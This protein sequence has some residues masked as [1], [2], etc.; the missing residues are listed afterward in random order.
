VVVKAHLEFKLLSATKSTGGQLLTLNLK[1]VGRSILKNLVVRLHHLGF[2]FSVDC[3]GCFVYALMP[4]SEENVTFQV[5]VSR[6]KRVYF[7]VSGYASGDAYF[8]ME[9][10]VLTIQKETPQRNF[11]LL[12]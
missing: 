3:A 4:N 5:F 2:K 11:L 10:P 6:L 7:S 1:N 8:F 9:S 12:T